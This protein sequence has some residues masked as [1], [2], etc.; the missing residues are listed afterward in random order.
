MRGNRA[1]LL[2]RLVPRWTPPAAGE[3]PAGPSFALAELHR[4]RAEVAELQALLDTEAAGDEAPPA[5]PALA[6]AV[7]P[8]PDP[9]PDEAPKAD[10]NHNDLADEQASWEPPAAFVDFATCLSA[11]AASASPVWSRIAERAD[12]KT[13]LYAESVLTSALDRDED[14]FGWL[15]LMHVA[16]R[17][18]VV[19]AFAK[20]VSSHAATFTVQN[21]ID[22]VHHLTERFKPGESRFDTRRPGG[23]LAVLQELVNDDASM[24]A[25]RQFVDHFTTTPPAEWR[26][27]VLHARLESRKT[28]LMHLHAGC[29]YLRG[30][31]VRQI[32]LH[33]VRRDDACTWDKP[34]WD[35][36]TELLPGTSDGAAEVGIV[37]YDDAV[38][39]IAY[40]NSMLGEAPPLTLADLS[41]AFCLR[42]RA[43]RPRIDHDVPLELPE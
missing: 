9:A 13:L 40:V 34:D 15:T 30:H 21:A 7:V 1:T 26:P 20:W 18:R 42:P 17:R 12:V 35:V 14:I 22:V 2:A 27:S 16:P 33:A 31:T 4:L 28:K 37:G 19:L 10:H 3:A 23:G 32:F 38:H 29:K 39:A 8:P 11:D 5:A 6:D 41:M 24:A 36:I 25:L 43:P